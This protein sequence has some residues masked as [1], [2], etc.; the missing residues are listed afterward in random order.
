MACTSEN[1]H[2]T[3]YAR[4]S[5]GVYHILPAE[6]FFQ[7]PFHNHPCGVVIA[8]AEGLSGRDADIIGQMGYI[9]MS[10]IMHHYLISYNDRL[11]SFFFPYLVPILVGCVLG[12]E[13]YL[14]VWHGER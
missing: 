2:D 7:Q 6:I 1:A 10:G 12:S 14:Y 9:R 13:S 3:Q 8:S 5:P 4:T 11:E